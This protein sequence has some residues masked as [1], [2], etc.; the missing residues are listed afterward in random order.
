[1]KKKMLKLLRNL[2]IFCTG[3]T[4]QFGNLL[5]ESTVSNIKGWD[6]QQKQ[7]KFIVFH[8]LI[9]FKGLLGSRS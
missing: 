4:R 3:T 6:V 2:S 5:P 8:S 7:R 1:M 9:E